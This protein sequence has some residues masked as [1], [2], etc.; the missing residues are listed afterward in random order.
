MTQDGSDGERAA[1]QLC[2]L[3]LIISTLSTIDRSGFVEPMTQLDSASTGTKLGCLT[4]GLATKRKS[5][6]HLM[7]CHPITLASAI[8]GPIER[9]R[10]SYLL[11]LLNS[12]NSF[13]ESIQ[14]NSLS[15]L[16]FLLLPL[17]PLC[18][19]DWT[20]KADKFFTLHSPLWAARY[21]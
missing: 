21:P 9:V 16:C 5:S 18:E 19:S 14:L 8:S 13:I 20:T 12:F 1:S 2:V 4:P 11:A 3:A 17:L 6:Q 10:P 15:A 7:L